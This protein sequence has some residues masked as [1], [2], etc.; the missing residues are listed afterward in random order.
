[1][2]HI[3]CV[4]HNAYW[5]GNAVEP[6]RSFVLLLIAQ[7]FFIS[8]SAMSLRKSKP[9]LWGIF[10]NRFK[11]S[12]APFYIYAAVMLGV[13]AVLSTLLLKGTPHFNLMPFEISAYTWRDAVDVIL[14]WDIPHC[15]FM[16]HLWFIPI[17]I[18]LYCSLSLQ[19]KLMKHFNRYVYVAICFALFMIAQAV[20]DI[21]FLRELLCYNVFTVTGYLFYKRDSEKVTTLIGVS[22]LALILANEFLLGGHFVPLQDHK[23]PPDWIYLLYCVMLLC[24]LSLFFRRVTLPYNTIFRI[25]NERG[26]TIYL[27][28]SLV[29]WL[30]YDMHQLGFLNTPYMVLNFIIDGILVFGLSTA[31]S[32]V[33][34]PLEKW[35]MRK[36]GLAKPK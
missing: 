22:A 16:A 21:S 12:I 6:Y 2:M 19:I 1:M 4:A 24:F 20:T 15:P 26:Y 17:Y 33:T 9:G 27:Y 8:G 32:C 36:V 11:R 13:V 10:V 18:I 35:V 5:L 30:V 23:F 14:C 29:L 34:Y 31:L 28:Q 7:A 3:P 25:W